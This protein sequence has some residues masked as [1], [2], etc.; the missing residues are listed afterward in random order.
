MSTN[1]LVEV[2]MLVSEVVVV[3]GVEVGIMGAT[4]S[5]SNTMLT[6]MGY[7]FEEEVCVDMDVGMAEATP[8]CMPFFRTECVTSRGE[9]ETH[10][11]WIFR[12]MYLEMSLP[13][14]WLRSGS[15]IR[16]QQ[17]QDD[18]HVTSAV[19]PVLKLMITN[20]Q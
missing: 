11:V 18:Q 6:V 13:T 2:D 10:L 1:T 3:L 7:M 17:T 16:Q 14:T 4:I 12:Q 19:R 20:L 15:D 8:H 5:I 9:S